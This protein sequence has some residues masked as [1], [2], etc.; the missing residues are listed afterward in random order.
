[1]EHVRFVSDPL[2]IELRAPGP[3]EAAEAAGAWS[4]VVDGLQGRLVVTHPRLRL[5]GWL[6]VKLQLRP[7]DGTPRGVW[8]HDPFQF[9]MQVTDAQGNGVAP[10]QRRR[11]TPFGVTWSTA[12]ADDNLI[13]PLTIPSPNG[14][15]E[16]QL[17]SRTRTWKLEPG[18]YR[19]S[20]TYAPGPDRQSG[21]TIA[22]GG[23]GKC[24]I[25][26]LELPPVEVEVCDATASRRD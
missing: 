1:M 20:G 16:A 11:S 9:E 12:S 14:P 23:P 7:A 26:R 5:S 4:K 22:D 25:E 2:E 19:I 10:T 13:I 24:W 15:G 21:R 6:E 8:A 3:G 17:D 18:T